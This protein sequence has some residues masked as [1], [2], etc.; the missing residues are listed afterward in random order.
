MYN[1]VSNSARVQPFNDYSLSICQSCVKI[2]FI[3]TLCII[4]INRYGSPSLYWTECGTDIQNVRVIASLANLKSICIIMYHSCQINRFNSF[5][6]QHFFALPFFKITQICS[7]G[8]YIIRSCFMNERHTL[9]TRI[10]DLN[11]WYIVYNFNSIK[12]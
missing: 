10:N 9:Q 6:L 7:D 8:N 1:K 5:L 4:I 12:N 11:G 3:N 2:A